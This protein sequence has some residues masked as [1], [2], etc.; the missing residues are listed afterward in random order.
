[1]GRQMFDGFNSGHDQRKTSTSTKNSSI[2]TCLVSSLS[3]ESWFDLHYYDVTVQGYF[4]ISSFE[5]QEI[6]SNALKQPGTLFSMATFPFEKPIATRKN[7]CIR[8]LLPRS[9]KFMCK[10]YTISEWYSM[11]SL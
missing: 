6:H 9:W 5:L 7:Y 1:M 3:G 2:T 8:S 10:H 4:F 11:L